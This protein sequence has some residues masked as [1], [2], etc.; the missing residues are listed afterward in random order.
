MWRRSW[1]WG[2]AIA[3]LKKNPDVELD[4]DGDNTEAPVRNLI[5]KVED[6]RKAVDEKRFSFKNAK[7]D[8][9]FIADKIFGQL[10]KYAPIGD[11]ALQHNP[12]VVALVWAGFRFLLDVSIY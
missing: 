2:E 12:D 3:I 1:L 5:D 7:G 9:V 4:D 8:D 10:K 6:L 11:I